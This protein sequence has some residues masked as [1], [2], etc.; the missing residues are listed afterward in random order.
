MITGNKGIGKGICEKILKDHADTFVLLGSR[1]SARGQ[2]AVDS[3]VE[4]L[5]ESVS[6]RIESVEVDVTN[7]ESVRSA[8]ASVSAKYGSGSLYG[9]VNN[10]GIGF[11]NQIDDILATNVYGLRRVTEAFLPLLRRTDDPTTTGRIVNIA[12]A[13]GPIF[14]T[15]LRDDGVPHA[16][17][18]DPNTSWEQVEDYVSH[19]RK[20]QPEV[21]T[22]SR[23]AYG[24]S[25]AWVNAYT[26]LLARDHP[27]LVV[28]SCT[29]GFI[30]TDLTKG[31]GAKNTPE[32]GA[33][34]ALHCL[35]A[36]DVGSGRYF[37]SD[38]VR[39]PLD[40]YRNPGDP[41]YEP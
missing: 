21:N 1:D 10:A 13:S 12:S 39:S 26:L 30:D 25:K 5:G 33:V 37:G 11:G 17:F 40:R 23:H 24:L 7:E 38:A 19:L 20:T 29:P 9:I 16:I 2:E 32:Q 15:K 18:T 6:G 31:M 36:P 27:G 3:I 41:A 35:F 8:A 34:S 22:E 28:N 14:L 4:K